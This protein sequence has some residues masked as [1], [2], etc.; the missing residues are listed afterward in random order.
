V[1]QD[2]S[3]T[4]MI[5]NDEEKDWMRPLLSLRNLLDHRMH[6]EHEEIGI[7]DHCESCQVEDCK[8]CK[9]RRNDQHLRDWRRMHGNVTVFR[10]ETVPGPYTQKSREAWLRK[11]LSAQTWIRA[12]GPDEVAE[13]DLIT[14]EELHEIRRIWVFDKHEIED[15]LPRIYAEET[16]HKFPGRPLEEHVVLGSDD[17]ALLREV[18]AGDDIH[19]E[20]TRALIAVERSYRTM[21]RR[22]GLFEALEAEV[23]RGFYDG[24]GDALERAKKM[25]TV[26]DLRKGLASV[27]E[28]RQLE[29]V[30]G[31]QK[32]AEAKE[33]TDAVS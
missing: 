6:C 33:C 31:E 23:R 7:C 15:S 5:Q 16:G 19:F 4:A 25:R 30:G 29:L 20:M 21:S 28:L 27:D 11:L 10:D 26:R 2:K 32:S 17:V 13:L 1:D 18:C 22:S 24:A 14:M 8:Q 9:P 12:N 3:M